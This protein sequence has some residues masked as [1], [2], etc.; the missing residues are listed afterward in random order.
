MI[1][2]VAAGT[3]R[4]RRTRGWL[5]GGTV[6]D[7]RS[8][9]FSPDLDIAVEDDSR[10]VAR[11]IAAQLGFPWFALST[12]H[13]AYRVMAPEG[14][15]DVAALQGAGIEDD[16]SRRDFTVNAMAL[17]LSG[18]DLVDPFG[19]SEHLRAGLL[20]A[21]SD[22]IFRDDPLR[23]LRA[24]RFRHVLGMRLDPSLEDLLRAQAGLVVGAAGERVVAEMVLTLAE[25]RT[26]A[27]VGL[28]DDL[29]LLAALLPEVGPAGD[30]RPLEEL[31]RLL[32]SPGLLASGE[33]A[34]ALT[35][36]LHVSVDGVFPRRVALRLAMLLSGLSPADTD[37]IARR[38]KL[39]AAMGSLLRGAAACFTAGRCA[40]EALT[41][42]AR[43]GR[44]LVSFLWAVEPWEPE[45]LLLAAAGL[46][47]G[48]P[49]QGDV[50]GQALPPV[51]IRPFLEAWA[52]RDSRGVPPPPV[53]GDYLMARLGV[54]P[55]PLLGRLLGEVRLAWEAGEASTVDDLL[56][57]ARGVLGPAAVGPVA[58]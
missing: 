38:L 57:V 46:A 21:V 58:G 54:L 20:V 6:R 32:S 52:L 33:T 43:T 41:A 29:G 48:R 55:G 22:G 12:R 3:L 56:A 44:S 47:A 30:R 9:R 39:S 24:P 11:D 49:L 27:A 31:D 1:E 53:D 36:R 15:L 26:A 8:G 5:V 7:R 13:G 40:E 45:V 25:G 37:R 16:L 18:G 14:H 10:Q 35:R 34:E 19:G 2:E 42:A 17:P 51:A 4:R 23:L 28:W 50:P